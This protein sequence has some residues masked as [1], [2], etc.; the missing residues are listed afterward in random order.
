MAYEVKKSFFVDRGVFQIF[1]PAVPP[2]SALENLVRNENEAQTVT[3]I[4]FKLRRA[5]RSTDH[6]ARGNEIVD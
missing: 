2:P 1:E 3:D 4:S 5:T 6:E